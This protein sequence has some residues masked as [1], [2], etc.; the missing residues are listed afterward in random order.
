MV[1]PKKRKIIIKGGRK[2]NLRHT[3]KRYECRLEWPIEKNYYKMFFRF[4]VNNSYDGE[5]RYNYVLQDWE[6]LVPLAAENKA[7]WD[8]EQSWKDALTGQSGMKANWNANEMSAKSVCNLSVHL[9]P[10]SSANGSILSYPKGA[11]VIGAAWSDIRTGRH[12][13]WCPNCWHWRIK[14]DWTTFIWI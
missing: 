7:H 2:R 11:Q 8:G 3:F 12:K 5:L 6:Q 9:E 14:A 10:Q 13:H 4:Y 1:N